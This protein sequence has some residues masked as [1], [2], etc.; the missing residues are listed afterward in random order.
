M[1]AIGFQANRRLLEVE[2]LT[3]DCRIGEAIFEQIT[4]PQRVEGQHAAA[5]KFGD[6]RAMALFQA[7][8]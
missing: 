2:K 8:C 3:Q 1:R 6:P 7:L 4:Q 5:L